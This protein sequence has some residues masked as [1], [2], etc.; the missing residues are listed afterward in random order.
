V[1][2][3]GW[4]ETL[5]DTHD[6]PI[7][8]CPIGMVESKKLIAKSPCEV[9]VLLNAF[10]DESAVGVAGDDVPVEMCSGGDM[11]AILCLAT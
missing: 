2:K 10:F 9:R 11:H 5:R 8:N 3:R 7:L 4:L 1:R 6:N